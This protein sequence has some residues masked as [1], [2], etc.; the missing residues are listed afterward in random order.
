[1]FASSCERGF[2]GL[3][4]ARSE[5]GDQRRSREAT[6]RRPTRTTF[7][8]S[9]CTERAATSLQCTP[10]NNNLILQCC[11]STKKN[12]KTFLYRQVPENK[13]KEKSGT[14]YTACCIKRTQRPKR[15]YN[16]GSSSWL[17]GASDIAAHYAAIQC[18]R[19]GTIGPAACSKFR[20]VTLDWA[21]L[22]KGR[23]LSCL[24]R[25]VG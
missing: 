8:R 4:R 23:R 11:L 19:Q 14:C 9:R 20:S 21:H 3:T 15:F 7:E 12:F 5:A 1:M 18:P 25:T 2:S 22:E 16:L 10:T 24:K 6:R 13:K 17:A